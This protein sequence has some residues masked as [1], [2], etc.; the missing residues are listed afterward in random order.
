MIEYTINW[1]HLYSIH[2]GAVVAILLLFDVYKE[3]LVSDLSHLKDK[4]KVA[5]VMAM[6]VSLFSS[7]CHMHT[8]VHFLKEIK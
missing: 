4:F 5:A 7:H 2:F 3:G 1:L 8:V 6:F